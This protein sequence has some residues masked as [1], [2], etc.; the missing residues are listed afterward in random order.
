ME[1]EEIVPFAII[2]NVP[3]FPGCENLSSEEERKACF[4]RKVQEHVK[5]HFKYPPTALEMGIKLHE[6]L[7]HCRQ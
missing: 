7:Q 1:E 2:E 5:K 6:S 3:V 4:N